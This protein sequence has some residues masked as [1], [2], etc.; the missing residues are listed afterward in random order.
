[1]IL[2]LENSF[3]IR[4]PVVSSDTADQRA[5]AVE[6]PTAVQAHAGERRSGRPTHAGRNWVPQLS[7]PREYTILNQ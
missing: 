4:Q 5:R 2:A 1:M 6:P 3:N 7:L